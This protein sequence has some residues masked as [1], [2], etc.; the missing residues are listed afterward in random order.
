MNIKKMIY[1]SIFVVQLLLSCLHL[2]YGWC[3]G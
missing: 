2:Q 1:P 3:S